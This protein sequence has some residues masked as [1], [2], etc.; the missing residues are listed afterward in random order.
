MPAITAPLNVREV[1]VDMQRRPSKTFIDWVTSLTADVN[2]APARITTVPPLEAQ[3]GS[4]STTPFATGALSSGLY[5]FTFYAR[6]TQAA[7]V[8]SSLTVTLSWTD[9]GQ[10]MA[11]TF[12]PAITGNT[13]TTSDSQTYTIRSDAASPIS[14]S[15]SYASAGGTPMVYSI[16]LVLERLQA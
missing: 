4:I 12:A 8:S 15:T 6:I 7:T 1:M 3:A 9:R 5:R 10:T 16:D 2:A 13:V 14:Y 11:K